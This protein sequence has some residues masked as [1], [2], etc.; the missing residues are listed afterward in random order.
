MTVPT[1][2]L[3][4]SPEELQEL[5]SDIEVDWGYDYDI[6]A[7]TNALRRLRELIGGKPTVLRPSV[8]PP[9]QGETQ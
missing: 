7:G 8:V 2:T 3:N 5:L 1:T 6:D 4:I 9:N